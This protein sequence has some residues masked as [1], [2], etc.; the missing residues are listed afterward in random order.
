MLTS[1]RLPQ[2]IRVQAPGGQEYLETRK[3]LQRLALRTVCQEARCPNIGECFDHGTATFMILGDV[4]TRACGFC[5]VTKGKPMAVDLD[6][7]ERLAEATLQLGMKHVVITSVDRDDLSDGGAGHFS[8]VIHAIKARSPQTVVEVL[9]P[10]FRGN[11]EALQTVVKAPL[12]VFNHNLETV[13]RLYQRARRGSKYER[14]LQVLAWAKEINPNL[15]TKSGLMLGLGEE[16]EEL[17]SVFQDLRAV[18]CDVLTL[19]QYL[20]PSLD[21]L[22]VERFVGP[23]EFKVLAEKARRLGFRHVEA[24]PLVRSSYHAWKHSET[25]LRTSDI[26]DR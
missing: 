4:C 21:Q 7:P 11:R 15:V 22:P 14:S 17:F 19:G 5:H 10:D 25:V 18:N 20:R 1:S 16:D 9:T 3:I 23:D 2:W 24:G 8:K 26:V 6:E 13:P 12:Q